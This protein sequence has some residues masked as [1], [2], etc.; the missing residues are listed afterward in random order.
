VAEVAVALIVVLTGLLATATRAS[1]MEVTPQEKQEMR[2]HYEKG[3]RAYDIGKFAEAIE[4]YQKV[5]EIGGDAAMLFNIAQAYRLADQP[6]EALRYYRRYL[7]RAPEARNRADVERKIADLDKAVQEHARAAPATPAA[8]APAPAPPSPV[9]P[10]PAPPPAAAVKPAPP[11][12]PLKPAAPAAV[13]APPPAAVPA[14]SPP[15]TAAPA[16]A[17]PAAPPKAP[18]AAAPA[19]AA[20]AAPPAVA[21]PPFTPTSRPPAAPRPS[22]GVGARRWTEIALLVAGAG[23]ITVS[24][25]EASIAR[26][27]ANKLTTESKQGNV[28]FDPAVETNG[29]RASAIALTS[30]LVGSAALVTGG[31]LLLFDHPAR[32]EG[33]PAAAQPAVVG[34][35]APLVVSGRPIGAGVS[36]SF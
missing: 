7:Q 36:W 28:V 8:P 18:P 3:N 35:L 20:A 14:P 29:K 25:I 19:P 15:V 24:A 34:G 30:A 10:T 1:A 31:L 26:D 33:A 6:A 13:A 9:A 11:A 4:E 32:R 2:Q 27:R 17:A 23:G 16:P 12:A 21:P 22:G 5:Y